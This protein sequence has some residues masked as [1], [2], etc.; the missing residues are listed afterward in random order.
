MSSAAR[1]HDEMTHM[2][3]ARA[4]VSPE[5]SF[6]KVDTRWL[7]GKTFELHRGTVSERRV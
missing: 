7:E 1:V 3:R 2:R 4:D 5:S 6:G